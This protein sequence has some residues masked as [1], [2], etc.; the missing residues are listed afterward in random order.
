I[1]LDVLAR[2]NVRGVQLNV[3]VKVALVCILRARH[4]ALLA[5]GSVIPA[6]PWEDCQ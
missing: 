4:Q 6:L 1:I 2:Y 3:D 5:R